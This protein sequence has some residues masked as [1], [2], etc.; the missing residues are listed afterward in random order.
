MMM[1]MFLL[2]ALGVVHVDRGVDDIISTPISTGSGT[3]G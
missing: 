1:K 3:R 2:F